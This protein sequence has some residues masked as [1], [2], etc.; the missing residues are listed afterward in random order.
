MSTTIPD[1]HKDLLDGPVVVSLSTV[2][3]DGQPQS[4][5]VWCSFDGSHILV[6]TARGRQKDKNLTKRPMATILAVDP[7]NPYR[8]LEIRGKV[9][10]VTEEGALDHINQ[11]AQIYVGASEYFGGVAPLEMKDQQTRVIY[12]IKPTRVVPYGG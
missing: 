6:N 11:L 8:Y 5:P 2:M 3:A 10:G 1:S 12:K 9:D 7:E 4:S